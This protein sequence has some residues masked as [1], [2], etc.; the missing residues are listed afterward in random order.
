M[1]LPEKTEHETILMLKEAKALPV[2][3]IPKITE[4]D[5]SG[6]DHD[7]ALPKCNGETL[8]TVDQLAQLTALRALNIAE[9]A[10]K[11]ISPLAALPELE[12]LN[13]DMLDLSDI[14]VFTL[15][16]KL[17]VLILGGIN[18]IKDYRPVST[19]L[20]LCELDLT[21]GNFADTSLLEPLTK[22]EMLAV[23]GTYVSNIDCVSY[24]PKLRGLDVSDLRL[25]SFEPVFEKTGLEIL[26]LFNTNITDLKPF[27]R[28]TKLRQ[29]EIGR[30]NVSSDDVE[31]LKQKNPCLTIT[32]NTQNAFTQRLPF[33]RLESKFS[34]G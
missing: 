30:C 24:M 17:R 8:E 16:N 15:L 11:D 7:F 28:L 9:T 14:S 29:L 23:D 26:N 5:L 21:S 3:W 2:E 33:N 12:L 31:F 34:F 20:H 10:V 22:L 1:P 32:S 27:V 19:L 6:E 18:T 4:L 25:D 13:A